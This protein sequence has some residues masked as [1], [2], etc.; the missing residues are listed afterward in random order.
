MSDDHAPVTWRLIASRE[1]AVKLRDR[2]FVLSTVFL[3]LLVAGSVAASTLIAGRTDRL[4]VA[5]LDDHAAELVELAAASARADDRSIEVER[6][7][8]PDA[9]TLERWVG[10]G[11]VDAGLGAVAADGDGGDRDGTVAGG[12]DDAV[13]AARWE[14]VGDRELDGELTSVLRSA[15][16]AAELDANATAAGTSTA[17]LLDGTALRERLLDEDAI[18]GP[19]RYIL[20]GAFAF[21]FYLTALVFGMSIA[22][23]VIEEKQNRVVEILA[24]A[25]PVR[26]LLRGK[27]VGNSVLAIAQVLLLA[28]VGLGGL[29]I[30]G[31]G[32]AL[33]TVLGASA[34]FVVFFLLGFTALACL[35][36]VAGSIA[37]R[38]EDLQ[39]TTVPLQAIV[40]VALFVGIGATGD[41]L[42]VASFVPLVSSVAM[43][44]RLLSGEV[45][46]W[47]PAVS[48]VLVAGAAALLFRLGARLYERSLLRTD[49]RTRYREALTA[50]D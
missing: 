22:Q 13:P 15:V 49:R 40:F 46:L 24:A 23:S 26:Q 28:A 38:Q 16:R 18:A 19:L 4:T 29:T 12:R 8:A 47:Q 39:A 44:V 30:A 3:L 21:L 34:W 45:P 11:T 41:A 36:A 31:R 20:A 10:D 42:A 33:A 1:M 32:D 2:T 9:E 17:A 48:A 5:T 35:W 27:I 37:T 50:D 14:V 43:P 25:V 7:R 6:R